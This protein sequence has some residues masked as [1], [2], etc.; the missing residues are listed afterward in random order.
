MSL[1][2]GALQGSPGQTDTIRYLTKRFWGYR[3]KNLMMY[4]LRTLSREL[5]LDHIYAVSNH[6]FY[7][8]NHLRLDRKLKTSLDEF[9]RETQGCRTSDERF[10]ELPIG[11]PRKRIDEVPSHKRNLYKKRFI[12]LRGIYETISQELGFWK[13]NSGAFAKRRPGGLL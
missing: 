5:N 12:L 7:A 4:A 6:G 9:W 13:L 10:Y 8:N 2:I 3:P 1:W 11:E